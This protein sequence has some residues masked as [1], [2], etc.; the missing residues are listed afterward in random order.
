MAVTM[1]RWDGQSLPSLVVFGDENSL[2]LLGA[3]T[4]DGFGI[5]PDP[6][7]RKLIRVRGLAV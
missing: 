3:Y 5:A 1:T 2:P 7:N 6:V 4:L